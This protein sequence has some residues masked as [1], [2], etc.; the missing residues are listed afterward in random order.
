MFLFDS[1]DEWVLFHTSLKAQ[2]GY[3][4][5]VELLQHCSRCLQHSVDLCETYYQES[6]N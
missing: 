4:A 5:G 3:R 1:F 2:P 6:T